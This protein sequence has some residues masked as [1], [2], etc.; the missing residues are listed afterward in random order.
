VPLTNLFLALSS[1]ALETQV[2][3][4]LVAATTA[5]TA[6]NARGKTITE[7]LQDIPTCARDI[8]RHGVRQGAAVALDV[9][10]TQYGNDLRTLHPIFPQGNSRE[11]FGELIG[12]FDGAATTIGEEV[13]TDNV[14]NKVF[15]AND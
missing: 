9:V 6:A 2:Q 4:L 1:S 5:T 10:H 7:R 8:A 11:N 15:L 13:N 3:D 14:V 12:E